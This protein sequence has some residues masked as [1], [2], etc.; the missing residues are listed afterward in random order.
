MSKKIYVK[1]KILG[2]AGKA[3]MAGAGCPTKSVP[4]NMNSCKC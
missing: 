2:S 4:C 3:S 1:P